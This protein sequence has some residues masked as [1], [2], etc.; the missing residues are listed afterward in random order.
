MALKIAKA[1]MLSADSKQAFGLGLVFRVR[2][3]VLRVMV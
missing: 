1:R 3:S 2:R